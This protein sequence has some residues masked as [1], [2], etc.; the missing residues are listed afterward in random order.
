MWMAVKDEYA[1]M[2][3]DDVYDAFVLVP[4]YL[5]MYYKEDIHIHGCVSKKLYKNVMNYLQRILCD[6]SDELFRINI[7][8]DGFKVADGEPEIIGAGLSCGV[9]SLSTVYDWYVKEDDQDYRINGLFFFDTGWNGDFHDDKSM[10]LC[11]ERYGMNKAAADELGLPLYLVITNFHSFTYSLYWGVSSQMGYFANYSCAF[12]LQRAVKKYYTSNCFSYVQMLTFALKRRGI[13][14]AEFSESYSVPL[15]RTEK[16][17]LVIDGCQYERSTKIARLAEWDIAKK[18]LSPCSGRSHSIKNMHSRNCSSC[19]KCMHVMMTLDAI[20]RLEDFSGIF[21][22]AEYRKHLKFE[23]AY[24]VY[25]HFNG[26]PDG[27]EPDIYVFLK[28]KGMK[29]PSYPAA[30]MYLF[31]RRATLFIKKA[32]RKIMGDRVYEAL[33]RTLK[34]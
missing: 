8:V 27:N 15:I 34:R 32:A 1:Y 24:A 19:R 16:L 12:G 18:Y 33:K 10:E 2:L 29:L 13:D 7:T 22:L 6:F 17:E 30:C 25:E 31:P 20:G 4:L 11:L 28:Q 26:I 21:D 3:S 14:F 5:G 23:K 9:D